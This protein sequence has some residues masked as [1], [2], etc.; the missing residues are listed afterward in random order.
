MKKAM[1]STLVLVFLVSAACTSASAFSWMDGK[2]DVRGNIQQTWNILT[3]EDF[4]DIRHASFRTIMRAEALYKWIKTPDL[5]VR[6]FVLGNYY[7]DWALDIDSPMRH[8]IREEAVGRHKYRDFRRPRDSEEWLTEAYVDIKYKDLQVK[9]G[10]QLVSWGETAE[11]RVA[12]VI[13]PLD[14]KYV[15]AFPDWEDFKIG[16]WM[17]RLYYTPKNAWQEL[18]FEL[19]VIPFD[20]EEQRMPVAGAGFFN[21]GPGMGKVYQKMWDKQRRDAPDDGSTCFEIGLRIKGYTDVLEGIDWAISH[22]YTRRDDPLID[23]EKGFGN[24]V[25]MLFDMPLEGGMY[26]YPN[27]NSTALTFS[28]TWNRIGCAIYGECVYNTNREYQYG[29]FGDI[30]EKDLVTTALKLSRSTMVP[31]L[32]R[33]NKNTAYTISLTWYQYWL[34]NHEYDK[35]SGSYI[36]GETGKD[37]SK[38]KF[39]L[40]VMTGFSFYTII[41]V[42]NIVYDASEGTTTV[43][44]SLVYQPGDHWQWM[45]VYQQIN[46]AGAARYQDQVILSMRYEFW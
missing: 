24:M 1:M 16:L 4:R 41:P 21:G 44:G 13:N 31:Y 2:L 30:K 42:A 38:T 39:T 6:F 22:F 26:V 43:V 18:A 27:Y 23:G 36:V 46:E 40:T 11:S 35:N 12:D 20:F 17:I 3:H 45:A 14:L 29:Q 33:W 15:I 32:S 28:T 34:L 8:S 19:I 5:D 7:Y 37:A 10:K 9:L 25:R